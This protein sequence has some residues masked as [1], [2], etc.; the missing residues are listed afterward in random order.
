MVIRDGRL[1]AFE[2]IGKLYESNA[3][4]RQAVDLTGAA[5]RT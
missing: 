4:Y 3:F 2:A 5:E 1:E